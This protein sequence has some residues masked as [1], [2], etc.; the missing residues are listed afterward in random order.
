MIHRH[1]DYEIIKDE[2]MRTPGDPFWAL[3]PQKPRNPFI[4]N[5]V[6]HFIG[7]NLMFNGKKYSFHLNELQTGKKDRDYY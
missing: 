2:M 7:L 3:N 6:L 5:T 4:R 1:G